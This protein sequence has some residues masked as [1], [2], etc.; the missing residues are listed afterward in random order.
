MQNQVRLC[1][2]CGPTAR[3]GEVLAKPVGARQSPSRL[4]AS[5]T[6]SVLTR[7][8]VIGELSL[9]HLPNTSIE[10]KVDADFLNKFEDDFD[11]GDMKR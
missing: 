5:D 6:A 9:P 8:A 10:K 3:I 2:L 1:A 7:T 4:T 11:E